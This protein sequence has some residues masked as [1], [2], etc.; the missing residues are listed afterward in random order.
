MSSAWRAAVRGRPAAQAQCLGG[1]VYL[2]CDLQDLNHYHAV[3]AVNPGV[4]APAG[5]CN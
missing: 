1:A 2:R 3:G 4:R 5:I